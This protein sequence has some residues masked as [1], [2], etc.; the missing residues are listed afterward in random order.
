MHQGIALVEDSVAPKCKPSQLGPPRGSLDGG[1]Q[2]HFSRGLVVKDWLHLLVTPFP[3]PGPIQSWTWPVPPPGSS[4]F[5][6]LL[7]ARDRTGS[8]VTWGVCPP[9]LKLWPRH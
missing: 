3:I 7:L 1:F 2:S 9:E 6:A 4:L 8:W 5:Q